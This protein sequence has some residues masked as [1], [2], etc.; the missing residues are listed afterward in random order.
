[1]HPL[2]KFTFKK[3]EVIHENEKKKQVLNFSYVK[4]ILH[5]DN[6]VETDICCRSRNIHNYLPCNIA[7]PDHTKNNIPYN[8]GNS[9][10]VKNKLR[11]IRNEH[12]QSICKDRNFILP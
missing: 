2:I 6:S 5:Q 1:M 10:T 3:P 7:H 11:N 4:I 8:L 9:E 12:L